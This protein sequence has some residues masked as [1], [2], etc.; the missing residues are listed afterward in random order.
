[1][2]AMSSHHHHQQYTLHFLASKIE[3]HMGDQSN[4]TPTEVYTDGSKINYQTGSAFCAIANEDIT[5]TWKGNLSPGNLVFQAEI[6]ALKVA[7][8]WANTANE[9]VNIW[10]DSESSPQAPKS[11]NV[12]SKITQDSQMTL[13]YQ[14][15]I[16][17]LQLYEKCN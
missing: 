9:E 10:S 3:S 12:K 11:F 6:L 1:M 2:K 17:E 8:E 16:M 7:I 13:H 15:R 5:K 14:P 4:R